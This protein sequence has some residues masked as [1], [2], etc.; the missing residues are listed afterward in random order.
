[1][2]SHCIKLYP[3]ISIPRMRNT[4]YAPRSHNKWNNGIPLF[5]FS[6]SFVYK[7]Y[8]YCC[9]NK[10]KLFNIYMFLFSLQT[11]KLKRI[12]EENVL[13][14]QGDLKQNIEPLM[15]PATIWSIFNGVRRAQHSKD[16]YPQTTRMVC[17]LILIELKRIRYDVFNIKSSKIVIYI[18]LSDSLRCINSKRSNRSNW[19]WDHA[20]PT[21]TSFVTFGK[22][23]E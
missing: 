15:D 19:T 3:L 21:S 6:F 18:E 16:F 10:F 11:L 14:L 9:R 22:V 8:D 7:F 12:L 17:F 5:F 2:F 1:M 13:M 4:L 20:F 23:S